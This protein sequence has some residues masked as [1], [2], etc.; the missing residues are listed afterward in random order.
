M[1]LTAS[2]IVS[3]I[4]AVPLVSAAFAASPA[5]RIGPE[6]RANATTLLGQSAP[7]VVALS[8][9]QFVVAW[10]DDSKQSADTSGTAV[11]ARRFSHSG[12]PLGGELLMNTSKPNDQEQVALARLRS[13]GFV[14]VW[15]DGSFSK[16]DKSGL[17]IHSQR[18]NNSAAKLSGQYQINRVAVGHAEDL[19]EAQGLC[20]P[21]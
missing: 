3:V 15:A 13:G 20:R 12:A 2:G 17:A 18:F 4:T 10:T 14:A 5:T 19:S 8:T 16:A 21:G 1:R 11:R 7:A 6:F 9:G